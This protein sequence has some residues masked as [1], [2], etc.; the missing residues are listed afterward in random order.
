MDNKRTILNLISDEIADLLYYDRKEDSSL[1]LGKIE[2]MI[3]DGEITIE[4]IV[5]E[6]RKELIKGLGTK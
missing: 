1:P 2:Q 6:F 3:E 5:E 4:E